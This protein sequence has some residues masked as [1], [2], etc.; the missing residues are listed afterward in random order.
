[1]AIVFQAVNVGLETIC[2]FRNVAV[3]YY[4]FRNGLNRWAQSR[5]TR[6]SCVADGAFVAAEGL[7]IA[8]TLRDRR[9]EDNTHGTER[10]GSVIC[11][12]IGIS[13]AAV[14]F[15]AWTISRGVVGILGSIQQGRENSAQE[16]TLRSLD[17]VIITLALPIITAGSF[18]YHTSL[19]LSL[20][21]LWYNT[22]GKAFPE[23][24][25]K[26]AQTIGKAVSRPFALIAYECA[27]LVGV[28]H[29]SSGRALFGKVCSIFGE[30]WFGDLPTFA[31]IE[32]QAEQAE[33][34]EQ[35]PPPPPTQSDLYTIISTHQPEPLLDNVRKFATA[36]IK[37][38]LVKVNGFFE[39]RS[40]V[41]VAERYRAR[42]FLHITQSEN[43]TPIMPFQNAEEEQTFLKELSANGIKQ[44]LCPISGRF[45]RHPVHHKERPTIIVEKE[46]L[47][48]ARANH[49]ERILIGTETFPL[50]SFEED[51]PSVG[52]L[53]QETL[54]VQFRKLHALNQEI[55]AGYKALLNPGTLQT[56]PRMIWD[57]PRMQQFHCR[58]SRDPIRFIVCPNGDMSNC[59][60]EKLLQKWLEENPHQLPPEWPVDIPFDIAHIQRDG[61]GFQDRLEMD[62][63][64]ISEE[65]QAAG[66]GRAQINPLG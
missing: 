26:L 24:L 62:L 12:V 32:V 65:I 28:V 11:I 5:A 56:I 19:S 20:A 27:A 60:E 51:S 57:D 40:I 36:Q 6:I 17:W 30:P 10:R 42:E 45:I 49:Q 46:S 63:R 21:P 44:V 37:F 50:E 31:T 52:V 33:Q 25:C 15:S 34:A 14:V 23:R 35:N 61:N 18:I 38:V 64:D 39:S 16:R 13:A 29:P 7:N 22:Q 53:A 2:S 8:R 55:A 43:Q 48:Q 9:N 58:I 47:D 1:M 66:L 54:Y 59:Y 41:Q 4:H 3:A